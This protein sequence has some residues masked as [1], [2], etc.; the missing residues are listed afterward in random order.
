[1]KRALVSL[2]V[3][4]LAAAVA[5]CSGAAPFRVV[6]TAAAAPSSS[7]S[8]S[9]SSDDTNSNFSASSDDNSASSDNSGASSDGGLDSGGSSQTITSSDG[10]VQM[11][12]PDYWL[13]VDPPNNHEVID[14]ADDVDGAYMSVYVEPRADFTKGLT[15]DQMLTQYVKTITPNFTNV[16][17]TAHV[18]GILGIDTSLGARQLTFTG[19]DE[20]GDVIKYL[21]TI[22]G[23][24]TNFYIVLGWSLPSDFDLN[25]VMYKLIMMTFEVI[26][27]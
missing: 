12:F 25:S 23:D 24:D 1:M 7:S 19:T 22:G 26:P 5:G 11:T 18:D 6:S 14:M 20:N 21:I 17:T 27:Q 2:F 16:S 15:V 9:S 4:V 3:V 10:S 8:Q 13:P